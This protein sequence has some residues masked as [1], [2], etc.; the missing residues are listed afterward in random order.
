[1]THVNVCDEE[2]TEFISFKDYKLG[3]NNKKV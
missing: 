2:K 1:M 3:Y